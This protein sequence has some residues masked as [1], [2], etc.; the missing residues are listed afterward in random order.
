MT[1]IVK[2]AKQGGTQAP[3]AAGSGAQAATQAVASNSVR[4]TLPSG[5]GVITLP[6]PQRLAWYGGIT[7]IAVLGLVEWPVAAL[8]ATGHLLA[9]DHHNRLIHDFG[10]ALG[11]A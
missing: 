3:T 2:P 11:E 6:A 5:L 10:E 9:E 7:V 4:V 1:T 8:L